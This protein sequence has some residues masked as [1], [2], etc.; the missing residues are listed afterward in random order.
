MCVCV[1]FQARP[2][3]NHSREGPL[4][5][6]LLSNYLGIY[7]LVYVRLRMFRDFSLWGSFWWPSTVVVDTLLWSAYRTFDKSQHTHI[8]PKEN[9]FTV[10]LIFHF[11]LVLIKQI[12]RVF[13]VSRNAIYIHK[14]TARDETKELIRIEWI[15]D[16]VLELEMERPKLS[17]VEKCRNSCGKE[18]EEYHWHG[19]PFSFTSL[20]SSIS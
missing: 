19:N 11:Q 14:K 3:G 7:W 20:S 17:S 10:R 9:P 15:N 18:M 8:S 2:L 16:I 6:N 13:C 1:Y 5:F 12:K 4:H